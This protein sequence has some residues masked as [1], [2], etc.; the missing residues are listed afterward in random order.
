VRKSLVTAAR[1]A[2]GTRYGLLETIRQFAE[3]QLAATTAIDT[4]RDRHARYYADQSLAHFGTWDGPGYRRVIDWLNAEFANLRTGFRW[5]TDQGDLVTASAIAA[6]AALLTFAL[7]RFEPLGWAEELIPAGTAA[8]VPQ[9]PRLYAAAAQCGFAGRPEAALEYAERALA[10]ETDSRYDPLPSGWSLLAEAN[11]HLVAGR[12]DRYVEICSDMAAQSGFAHAMGLA[13]LTF[14]LPAIGRAEEARAIADEALAVARARGNPFVTALALYASGRAFMEADPVRALE[15]FRESI[16][17]ARENG[18]P[19]IVMATSEDA[20]GLEAIHGDLETGLA[21][22]DTT[23]DT[24]H[25]S[26]N[27]ADTVGTLASL[28]ILFDRFDRAE[29]A[30][31][32][33]GA[34][35]LHTATGWVIGLDDFVDHLRTVLGA[36]RF[37]ECVA[38]GASME[39]AHAVQYAHAQ[40]RLAQQDLDRQS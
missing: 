28:A 4:I 18:V 40:I 16:A 29:P 39:L 14:G 2:E 12:M 17:Y 15:I 34:T 21:L 26:G 25:Q 32:I 24:A 31:T 19:Y 7:N 20:A 5:A 27:V 22:F 6:T 10:L 1:A 3:D 37:D 35:T 23:I 36:S 9:L 33:Y 8:D 11:A 13:S 30:A 38:A